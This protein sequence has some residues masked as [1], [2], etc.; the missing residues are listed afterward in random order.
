VEDLLSLIGAWGTSGN[1]AEI[2]APYDTINVSDLLA[3]VAAFGSCP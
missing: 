2:V 3:I 1:G